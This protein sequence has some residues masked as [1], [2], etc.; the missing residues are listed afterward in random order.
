MNLPR[1]QTG[2]GFEQQGDRPGD[3]RCSEARAFHGSKRKYVFTAGTLLWRTRVASKC[4][5]GGRY[6]NAG[7]TEVRLASAIVGRSLSYVIINDGIIAILA[8][9]VVIAANRDAVVGA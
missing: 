9:I 6:S 5:T 4:P 8:V 7:R 2:L 3:M 1:A